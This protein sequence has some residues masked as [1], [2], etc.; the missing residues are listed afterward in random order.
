[1]ILWLLALL[2]QIA[3]HMGAK[4]SQEI[5]EEAIEYHLKTN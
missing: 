5:T 4:V 3:D 2:E 1:V